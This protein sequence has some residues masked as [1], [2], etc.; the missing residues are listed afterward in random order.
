M[1]QI[2]VDDI[3][4]GSTN[5]TFC[6]EFAK[7][8]TRKF[9]M[10]MM[11]ELKFFLGFQVKQ[12]EE[13]T[14]RSQTKYTQDILKKFDMENAKPNKTPMK[15]NG[16]LGLDVNGKPVDQ[17]VYRSMIGS[18]LIFVHLGPI[19]CLVCVCVH[20]FKPL[21]WSVIWWPLREF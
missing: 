14:F 6:D 9:E 11:G 5:Q 17:K 21:L 20:V 18:L 2:Y 10:S 7:I 4:F 1:C 15:T 8:M 16:H 12:L 3:I 13:G 19:S